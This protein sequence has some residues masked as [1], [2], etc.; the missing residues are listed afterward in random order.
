MHFFSIQGDG[1]LTAQIATKRANGEIPARD[2][3]MVVNSRLPARARDLKVRPGLL[4]ACCVQETPKNQLKM[5]TDRSLACEP[6]PTTA[7][8]YYTMN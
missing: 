7:K 4:P 3:I 8:S 2:R 1:D 5:L 6:P